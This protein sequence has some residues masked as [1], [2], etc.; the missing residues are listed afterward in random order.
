[1]NKILYQLLLH[2]DQV[3]NNNLMLLYNQD[4]NVHKVHDIHLIK[5]NS[6]NK[7]YL[8]HW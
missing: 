7:L 1:M 2:K 3:N 6:Y 8:Y 5:V 4:H